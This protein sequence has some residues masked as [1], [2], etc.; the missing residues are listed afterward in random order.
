M[1]KLFGLDL[2]YIL[3]TMRDMNFSNLQTTRAVLFNGTVHLCQSFIAADLFVFICTARSDDDEGHVI[4][5]AYAFPSKFP[6]LPTTAS[7]SDRHACR[8]AGCDLNYS[9]IPI[10][11]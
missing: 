11:T 2:V 10:V 8:P 4:S 9:V 3:K 6:L 7:Q 1:V 5:Y